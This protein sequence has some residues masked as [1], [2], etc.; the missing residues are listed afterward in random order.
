MEGNKK[1]SGGLLIFTS[2]A[3]DIRISQDFRPEGAG[4]GEQICAYRESGG[5]R[6]GVVGGVAQVGGGLI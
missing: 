3:V 4:R 2:V 5:M 1:Y 6:E